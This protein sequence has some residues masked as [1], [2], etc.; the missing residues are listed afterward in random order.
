MSGPGQEKELML[1]S[2]NKHLSSYESSQRSASNVDDC[3]AGAMSATH[4][5]VSDRKVIGGFLKDNSD[6]KPLYLG[7]HP[8][9]KQ[10]YI[11][12]IPNR[13]RIND[14]F[15]DA[16]K[17]CANCQQALHTNSYLLKKSVGLLSEHK[18]EA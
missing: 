5:K 14:G 3:S 13:L 2:H 8:V 11:V 12:E 16:A 4:L 9:G 6:F 10:N 17:C 18:V 15:G 1:S 7:H